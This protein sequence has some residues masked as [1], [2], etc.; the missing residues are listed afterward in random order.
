M[1]HSQ[2]RAPAADSTPTPLRR[3]DRLAPRPLGQPRSPRPAIQVAG[4]KQLGLRHIRSCLSGAQSCPTLAAASLPSGAFPFLCSG[5][6]LA[7]IEV[8]WWWGRWGASC[9]LDILNPLLHPPDARH[10]STYT[11][12]RARAHTHAR[13]NARTH[14][15]CQE[16]ERRP[17]L[18]VSHN[19][20]YQQRDGRQPPPQRRGF[21]AF[22]QFVDNSLRCSSI[23]KT[24]MSP[25]ALNL[26]IRH[27]PRH[28][29]RTHAC[30]DTFGALCLHA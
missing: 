3:P 21:L 26:C 17:Q 10:N 12:T 9:S 29:S 16:H 2:T 1:R 8:V 19:H 20:D 11:R 23:M 6:H 15:L 24:P 13:T 18:S 27:E 25:R 28:I 30:G 7:D 22:D 14:V 5:L 4:S